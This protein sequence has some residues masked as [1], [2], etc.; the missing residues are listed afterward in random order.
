MAAQQK[1]VIDLVFLLDVSGSMQACI[2]AIKANIGDFVGF[3]AVW[4][5]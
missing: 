2:D 3:F 5:G 4:C 1:G